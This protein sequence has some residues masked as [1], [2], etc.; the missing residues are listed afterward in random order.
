MISENV[1]RF[2]FQKNESDDNVSI[3]ENLRITLNV[4]GV[5]HE[6][7]IRMLNKIP[8]SRLGELLRASTREELFSIALII[9]AEA[10]H[11]A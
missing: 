8:N 1:S 5:R 6:V 2:E 11:A 7:M 9:Y 4:G 10:L 3:N